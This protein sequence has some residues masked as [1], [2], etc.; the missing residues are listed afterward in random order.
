M[1]PQATRRPSGLYATLCTKRPFLGL[2][3]AAEGRD[4]VLSSVPPS[5]ME[6]SFTPPE[7]PPA[8]AMC[9]GLSP[10]WNTS[11]QFSAGGHSIT[12]LVSWVVQSQT[13]IMLSS[14]LE[15]TRPV[16]LTASATTPRVCPWYECTISKPS[17]VAR[18]DLT[19]SST[20]PVNSRS[21]PP[22]PSAAQ[23]TLH[24]ESACALAWCVSGLSFTIAPFHHAQRGTE[25]SAFSFRSG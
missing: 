22:A 21:P 14:A 19:F 5:T 6:Y 9:S 2:S 3:A 8:T 7:V 20:D 10:G 24:T 16:V 12:T 11:S 25:R 4:M 1:A 13:R 17:P 23:A 15:A 18:Q